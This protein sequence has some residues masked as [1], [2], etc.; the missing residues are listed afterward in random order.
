MT[1]STVLVLHRTS[2]DEPHVREAVQS[3][4]GRGI[5]LRL[6]RAPTVV[7]AFL[8]LVPAALVAQADVSPEQGGTTTSLGLPTTWK[9]YG[10]FNTGRWRRSDPNELVFYLNGSVYRDLVNP[11]TGLIGLQLD[12]YFGSRSTEPDGGVRAL[13]RSPT[14]RLA[15]G[16]DW[17]FRDNEPDFVLSLIRF[18]PSTRGLHWQ[19][20]AVSAHDAYDRVPLIGQP[21]LVITGGEDSLIDPGNSEILAERIPGAELQFSLRL[22]GS[23]DRTACAQLRGAYQFIDSSTG[24]VS[25]RSLSSIDFSRAAL[26]HSRRGWRGRNS[27]SSLCRAKWLKYSLKNSVEKTA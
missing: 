4:R 11:L 5:K 20:D 23:I 25:L 8:V 6:R 27:R 15:G 21:T 10:G 17:N 14:L 18:P 24:N 1:S 13:L 2:A 19:I 3:V 16:V 7:L 9:F 22:S 26:R 12:G